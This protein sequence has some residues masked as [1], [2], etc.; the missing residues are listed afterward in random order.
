MDK[1]TK[2]EI[3]IPIIGNGDVIN[4]EK[5]AEMLKICDGVMIARGAIGDPLIF[6]RVLYYLETGK[7]K[8]FDFKKDIK[9]FQEYLKLCEKYKV[10]N[11]PIIKHLGCKFIKNI[12]GASV[13]RFNLMKCKDFPAIKNFF[14]ALK[15]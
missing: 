6:S 3:S 14:K 11:I 13:M 9:A 12:P 10:T 1:K 4:E 2:K 5:A 7:K 8:P 15:Y